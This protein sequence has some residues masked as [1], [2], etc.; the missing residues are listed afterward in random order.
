MT[1]IHRG[2]ELGV[3]NR[4]REQITEPSSGPEDTETSWYIT[5]VASLPIRQEGSSAGQLVIYMKKANEVR[6]LPRTT[7]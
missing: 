3:V 6:S 2:S 1:V 7:H 5:E 4:P